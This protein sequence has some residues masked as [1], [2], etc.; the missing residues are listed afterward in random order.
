MKFDVAVDQFQ[1]NILQLLLSKI[2]WNMG[3]NWCFTDGIK[4]TFYAGM[5]SNMDTV[6]LYILI[7]ILLILTLIQGHRSAGKQQLLLQ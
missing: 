5:H 6:V 7:I 4:T 1:L 2:Y 3:N